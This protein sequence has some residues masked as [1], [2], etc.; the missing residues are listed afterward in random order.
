MHSRQARLIVLLLVLGC[1]PWVRGQSGTITITGVTPSANGWET[2]VTWNA[3]QTSGG[4]NKLITAE[5]L[6]ELRQGGVPTGSEIFESL[7]PTAWGESGCASSA[8]TQSDPGTCLAGTTA[9][10]NVFGT[11]FASLALGGCLTSGGG[12]SM[13]LVLR[14]LTPGASYTVRLHS[15]LGWGPDCA[16]AATVYGCASSGT[17]AFTMPAGVAPTVSTLA[18]TSVTGSTATLNGRVN[19]QQLAT[20]YL[21]RWGTTPGGPYPNPTPGGALGPGAA[22][23]DSC[24]ATAGGWVLN[25]VSA[26]L[27]GL[28]PGTTYYYIAEATNSQG[29]TQGSEQSFTALAVPTL[30]TDPA[31]GVD[32]TTATLHGIVTTN[33]LTASWW[34]EFGASSGVY[35]SSTPGGTVPGGTPSASV[36][37]GLNGL[38]PNTTYYFRL[39]GANANGTGY[40]IERNFATPASGTAPTVTTGAATGITTTGATVVGTVNPQGASTSWSFDVGIVSGVYTWS[41]AGGTLSGSSAQSVSISLAGLTSATTYYYRARG[42]SANGTGYGAEASFVTATD[43]GASSPTATT[44]LASAV[45]YTSAILQ[46]TINAGGATTTYY[47][48]IGTSPGVYTLTSSSG[49]VTGSSDSFVGRSVAGLAQGTT[50]Y[51]RARGS[52]SVGSATGAELSFTTLTAPAGVPI[53]VTL[54]ASNITESTG[55]LNGTYNPNGASSSQVWF[56]WGTTPSSLSNATSLQNGGDGSTETS[57]TRSL[58]GLTGGGTY[59]FRMAC[60]TPTGG[61]S[62]GAT[63]S[64]TTSTTPVSYLEFSNFKCKWTDVSNPNFVGGSGKRG[65]ARKS[66]ASLT[67]IGTGIELYSMLDRT[68]GRMKVTIDGAALRDPVTIRR[69]TADRGLVTEV[70]EPTTRGRKPAKAAPLSSTVN[71]YTTGPTQFQEVVYTISGLSSSQHTLRVDAVAP[72]GTKRYQIFVDAARVSE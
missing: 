20:S 55:V 54:D 12:S 10:R 37:V 49:T 62:Y 24:S 57:Y 36:S 15:I 18:A 58:S 45:S 26:P 25:S 11:G 1:A 13:T 17:S 22:N 16:G 4:T 47:F 2:Y 3:T 48:E 43:P 38:M 63:L 66:R 41:T 51:Y 31:T 7:Y 52:N 21:F 69:L 23:G 72:K 53:A 67:F 30:T 60:S 61:T 70:I 28:T 29:T 42:S 65:L 56:E 50:Y 39:A 27:T 19:P 8:G 44:E 9:Y 6:V 46:G 14:G 35:P 40:G 68:L 64:F 5:M 34:Y 33:G 71:L 59:Y 32:S